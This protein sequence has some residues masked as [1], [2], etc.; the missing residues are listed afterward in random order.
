VHKLEQETK[1]TGRMT[2]SA[3]GYLAATQVTPRAGQVIGSFSVSV[4][5]KGAATDGD[6]VTSAAFEGS[7]DYVPPGDSLVGHTVQDV[8]PWFIWGP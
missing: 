5:R 3:G 8:V 7:W 4:R 6:L 2:S 1:V